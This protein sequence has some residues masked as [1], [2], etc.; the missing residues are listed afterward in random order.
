MRIARDRAPDVDYTFGDG[1]PGFL[2][3]GMSL[4]IAIAASL[5][6]PAPR[7][8]IRHAHG[9]RPAG[10]RHHRREEG[11]FDSRRQNVVSDCLLQT[12]IEIALVIPET[13]L[14]EAGR[15]R[16]QIHCRSAD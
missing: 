9:K 8:E 11:R 5:R 16:C 13:A 2:S 14:L 15:D 10:A 1:R 4:L 7:P 12:A 6:Y 3:F